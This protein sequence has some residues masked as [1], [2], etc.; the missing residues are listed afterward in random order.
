[1]FILK[2]MFVMTEC[3]RS[4]LYMKPD[5]SSHPVLCTVSSKCTEVRCC[6]DVQPVARKFEAFIDI[7]PCL[8][9]MSVGIEDYKTDINL[10]TYTYGE[11]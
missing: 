1:M 7:D 6:V 4:S 5:L 11:S 2:N 8:H 3:P 9:T 10:Q